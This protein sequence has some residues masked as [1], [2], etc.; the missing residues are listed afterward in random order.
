M[1]T[2]GSVVGVGLRRHRDR[3]RFWQRGLGISMRTLAI[4]K[5]D[6]GIYLCRS[7]AG[8][9]YVGYCAAPKL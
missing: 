9:I 1:R 2:P 5:E 7:R 8:T 3:V 6:D 4:V